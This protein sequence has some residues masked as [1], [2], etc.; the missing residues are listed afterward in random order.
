VLPY[1]IRYRIKTFPHKLPQEKINF[2][3]Y[4]NWKNAGY[5][6]KPNHKSCGTNENKD[7][8]FNNLPEN[9]LA[10]G[11]ATSHVAALIAKYSTASA[12]TGK[13][14][15]SGS[16]TVLTVFR[17]RIRIGSGFSQVDGSV[18][19]TNKKREKNQEISCFEVPDVLFLGLKASSVAGTSLL[20]RP[21]D[22]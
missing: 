10:S 22:M 2:R 12:Y 16:G 13:F 19:G 9:Y 15:C 1:R 3:L 18:S 5:G 14:I 4:I 8:M 11:V 17:I 20:W 7:R 21:R 6:Y